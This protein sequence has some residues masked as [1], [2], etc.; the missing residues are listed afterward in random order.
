MQVRPSG[1][2]LVE[3]SGA[4]YWSPANCAQSEPEAQFEFWRH[5]GHAAAA[6]PSPAAFP[7]VPTVPPV[8][9]TRLPFPVAHAAKLSA[10]VVTI[11]TARIC[12]IAR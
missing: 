5:G 1:Q 8:P 3:Q 9:T 11:R 4:Q 6:P 7:P 12:I 2:A 10:A